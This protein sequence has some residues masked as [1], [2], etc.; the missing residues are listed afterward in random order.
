MGVVQKA[1]CKSSRVVT[2]R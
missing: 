2:W 1:D